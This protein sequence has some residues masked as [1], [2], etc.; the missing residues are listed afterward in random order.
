MRTTAEEIRL[1]ASDLANHLACRH[2]TMLDLEALCGRIRPPVWRAP[3]LIVLQERGFEHERSFLGH[4]REQGL[5]IF[6]LGEESS[7]STAFERT[8]EA[9]RSGVDVIAQATLATGRWYGR[10]D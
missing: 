6:E 9:M 2:L 10:A 5:S 8:C 4:L 7:P 3:W 1:S